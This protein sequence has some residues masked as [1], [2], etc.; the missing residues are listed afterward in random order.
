MKTLEKLFN[1]IK[2]PLDKF[3]ENIEILWMNKINQNKS[4]NKRFT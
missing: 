1:K 3:C 2:K 4:K